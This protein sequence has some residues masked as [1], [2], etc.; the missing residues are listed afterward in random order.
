MRFIVEVTEGSMDLLA[1]SRQ[2][3]RKISR[4][5][6][7]IFSQQPRKIVIPLIDV[8]KLENK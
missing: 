5:I 6:L 2:M 7:R 3:Q 1:H 8:E 4:I